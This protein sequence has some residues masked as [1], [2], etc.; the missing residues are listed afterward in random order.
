[1]TG[2]PL[3]GGTLFRLRLSS[4]RPVLEFSQGGGELRFSRKDPT[5]R[6]QSASTVETQ[7]A[8]NDLSRKARQK[9]LKQ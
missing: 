4:S 1:M 3:G 8:W 5:Y 6:L 9:R 2:G 7:A